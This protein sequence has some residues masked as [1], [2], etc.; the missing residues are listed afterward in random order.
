MPD[1]RA[2][3]RLPVKAKVHAKLVGGPPSKGISCA[4]WLQDVSL[5]GLRFIGRK[6][7]P[8]NAFVTLDVDFAHPAESCSLRGQVG[9]LCQER[10]Q[11]YVIGIFVREESKERLLAWRHILE[12]RSLHD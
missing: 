9:W 11:R 6:A 10:E 3:L 4:G 7:L 2:T 8:L 1:R 5:G 12:R